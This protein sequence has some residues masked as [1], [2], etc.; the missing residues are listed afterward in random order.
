M[1]SPDLL[2]D[3]S[4]LIQ[5]GL[6]KLDAFISEKRE[7]GR[8]KS[9]P[10][11]RKLLMQNFQINLVEGSYDFVA[12]LMRLAKSYRQFETLVWA[13]NAAIIALAIYAVMLLIGLP[14]FT[15]FYWQ[16]F[17]PLAESPALFSLIAGATLA[18]FLRRRRNPDLF[19]L[20]DTELSEEARTAYDNRNVKSFFMQSLAEDVKRRLAAI[21]PSKILNWREVNLR[22]ALAAVVLALTV[23]ISYSQISA[24]I[25]PADFQSFSDIAKSAQG[26][27]GSEPEGN[28]GAKVNLSGGIYGKPS[29]AILNEEKLQLMLYPGL[30]AGS[31]SRET[32]PSER[33]FQTGQAGEPAAVPSELYIENLPPQNKDIIKKYFEQLS[34]SSA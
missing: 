24:D 21:K 30:G 16:G 8:R 7:V 26:I 25:S 17:F 29:L 14:A 28:Q 19:N 34:T 5:K 20:F 12:Q 13:L 9:V 15:R 6:E 1:P 10:S 18:T 33:M 27:F 4:T 3:A 32:K 22:I 11:S 2:S 31:R 23:F